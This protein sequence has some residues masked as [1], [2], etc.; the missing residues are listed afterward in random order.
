[1]Q[2]I[3]CYINHIEGYI[4]RGSQRDLILEH[5]QKK[6]QVKPE[7]IREALG[8]ELR[9]NPSSFVLN[10]SE[11][12]LVNFNKSKDS[13]KDSKG[14]IKNTTKKDAFI[15]FSRGKLILRNPAGKKKIEVIWYFNE[16]DLGI[17]G[18]FEILLYDL[19]DSEEYF[20]TDYNLPKLLPEFEIEKHLVIPESKEPELVDVIV[21]MYKEQN[22]SYRKIADEIEKDTGIVISHMKVKRTIQKYSRVS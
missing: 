5:I 6:Y 7:E 18:E 20:T 14:K 2:T 17:K 3:R 19:R 21:K 11:P 4:S 9:I 1:M 12:G 15:D 16:P 22:Y 8:T 13:Y 10:Y